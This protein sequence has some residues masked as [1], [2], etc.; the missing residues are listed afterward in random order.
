MLLYKYRSL[1]SLD[2]AL[3]ILLN[4]RLYCSAYTELNDPFEGQFQ[5]IPALRGLLGSVL[6]LPTITMEEIM[7]DHPPIRVSSL[8]K[9]PSDVRMWSLYAS[10]HTG[11]SIEI[12]FDHPGTEFPLEVRYLPH[13]LKLE[14]SL[15]DEIQAEAH[16]AGYLLAFKTEHWCYE[17][18][19][20]LICRN[21][22][23]HIKGA[24]RR[25]LVGHR[26]DPQKVEIL[27]KVRPDLDFYRTTLNHQDVAV[28]VDE[29]IV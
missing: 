14:Q 26:A 1:D 13:I 29:K 12:D 18:E 24:I 4:E 8:S 25:V 19:Y 17:Q 28:I 20:R 5:Q 21:T 23:S 16:N 9:T 7:K 6:P 2:F 11:I 15:L 27:R 10:S 3:D 22:F